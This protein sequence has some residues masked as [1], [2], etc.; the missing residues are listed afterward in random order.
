MPSSFNT[1]F[2]PALPRPQ[3]FPSG[4]EPSLEFPKSFPAGKEPPLDRTRITKQASSFHSLTE[5]KV[6]ATQDSHF[7][8]ADKISGSSSMKAIS[9]KN[10]SQIP[11]SNGG[12]IGNLISKVMNAVR[13]FFNFIANL[14]PMNSGKQVVKELLVKNDSAQFESDVSRSKFSIIQGNTINEEPSKEDLIKL[15]GENGTN[16]LVQSLSADMVKDLRKKVPHGADVSNFATSNFTIEDLGSEIRITAE[17]PLA[18]TTFE[19][20]KTYSNFM[21]AKRTIKISKEDLKHGL[22]QSKKDKVSELF[23]LASKEINDQSAVTKNTQNSLRTELRGF[24]PS[25]SITDGLLRISAK[26]ALILF[27]TPKTIEDNQSIPKKLAPLT[28]DKPIPKKIEKYSLSEDG[29]KI[30]ENEIRSYYT[31]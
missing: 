11:N 19:N 10:I 23:T 14:L 22:D 18:T 1:G 30:I 7:P 29:K 12:F 16:L 31:E 17:F 28:E 3:S 13:D 5:T 21:I 4:T 27:N 20:Q 15:L 6:N 2:E 25:L 26:D 9:H 24:A 8:E